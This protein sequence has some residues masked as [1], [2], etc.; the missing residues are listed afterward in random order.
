[1]NSLALQRLG[2]LLAVLVV[3]WGLATLLR[4][5]LGEEIERRSWPGVDGVTSVIVEQPEDTLILER[6]PE[7]VWTING[8]EPAA[9]AVDSTL[10]L[11][12]AGLSGDLASRT[13]ASH[14]RLGVDTVNGT[15]VMV[16]RGDTLA[17]EFW[18]GRP[19]QVMYSI[20]LR[21]AGDSAVYHYQGRLAALLTQS[22]ELWR[23]R[24]VATVP[25]DAIATLSVVRPGGGYTV[26]RAEAW[27]LGRAATDTAQV[28]RLL[29]EFGNLRVRG[30]ATADEAAALTFHP[31]RQVNLQDAAGDTLLALQLD[32]S[33]AGWFARRRFGGTVWRLDGWM[34]ARLMPPDSLLV[35]ADP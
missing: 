11:L 20:Y 31:V 22:L 33:D 3:G 7:G 17:F 21:V 25:A 23:E 28:A 12:A 13:I 24:V 16:H 32:S 4:G 2:L 1:M 26:R 9:D 10:T 19:G 8:F 5:D 34:V 27:R 18:F 30:F 15:H 14:E 6:S 35:R 29:S